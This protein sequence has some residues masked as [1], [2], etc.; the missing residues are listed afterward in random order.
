MK[1]LLT[2][3][4]KLQVQDKQVAKL[5]ATLAN[6]AAACNW[7]NQSVDPKLTNN[8]R[9][10][11]LTYE[12]IREQF[13]LSANLAIRAI[14]R[15]AGNRKTAK[16]QGKPVKEFK[17][18]S[19]DYDAR[20][21]AYREKDSSVSLTLVGGRERFNLILGNYQI[22]KLK[23]R[24][25]TS[26]T[27][28][29]TRK[30]EYFINIQVKDEAPEPIETKQAIGADLGR[31]DICVTSEGYT[32]SGKQITQIRNHHAKLRAV[33][34][35]KAVK[36]TRSSRRRCRRLL[37]RLSGRERR[38]QKHVNHVV[39]KT[40]VQAALQAN[41]VIALEDLTG[42]RERTN[43]LPRSKK[44][45]RLSNSWS[46]FELRQFISYKALANGV[47][48]V[49]IDPRYTSKTCHYCNVIGERKGKSF[50]C[51]NTACNWTG[52]ADYNGATNIKKLGVALVNPP[53]RGSELFC[54][55]EQ[56][57]LGL[58]KAPTIPLCG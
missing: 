38:F 48:V 58:P 39:S 3:S 33:L 31:T 12:Q 6:F 56:V 51:I 20:I 30:G 25:P 8:V 53:V 57:V 40:L 18:T 35:H 5:E 15:V 14:N 11:A 50:K 54:S 22:G 32:A 2:I 23:G 28:V 27:L 46:F 37:Q 13:G 42:I 10:Q 34:Q 9:I 19:A 44:E 55:L 52:D 49:L 41:A 26:A 17:P 7:I 4:C 47:E 29:K 21:F 43:Q 36:G 24:K 16:H 1:T 45:R